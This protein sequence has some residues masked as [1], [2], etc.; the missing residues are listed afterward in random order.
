MSLICDCIISEGMSKGADRSQ[1]HFCLY[2]QG[3]KRIGFSTLASNL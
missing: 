3:K 1:A 2:I